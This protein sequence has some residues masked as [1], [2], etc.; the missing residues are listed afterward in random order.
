MTVTAEKLGTIL[1]QIQ[2]ELRGLYNKGLAVNSGSDNKH[3]QKD[4]IGSK[5]T[6]NQINLLLLDPKR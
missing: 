2:N 3:F 1:N 5:S 4:L 6:V